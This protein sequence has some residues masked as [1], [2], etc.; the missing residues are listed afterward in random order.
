MDSAFT[1]DLF[2]VSF[3]TTVVLAC[4]IMIPLVGRTPR[5]VAFAMIN[6]GFLGYMLSVDFVVLLSGILLTSLFLRQVERGKN[7]STWLWLGGFM[8]LAIFLVHKRP[9]FGAE[10]GLRRWNPLLSIIGYSYFAL[11]LVEVTRGVAEQRHRSPNLFELINYLLPFHMISAGPI[12]SYDDFVSQPDTPPPLGVPATLRAVERIVS[13]MFKKFVLANA[14]EAV[15]LS[16]FRAGGPYFFL[17]TQINYVWLFLD[18]SAYSDIAVGIGTLMG[19]ATPEN[20]NRPYIARNCIDYWER[21]HISL[22]QFI[23][24]NL[25][26]PLQLSLVRRTDGRYPLVIASFAFAVSFL[27]C[28]L[29]H[30]IGLNWLAWGAYHALGLIICNLYRE[31]LLKTLGRKGLNRYLAN[32]WIRVLAIAVTFEF[33]AFSLVIVTYP[34]SLFDLVGPGSPSISSLVP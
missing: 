12:Q 16:T 6:L 26:I 14:L 29:W 22:S 28:G 17:E 11:R 24:R 18:F 10:L 7:T 34:W 30:N 15:F 2:S 20:F 23:R 27:L 8:A 31:Y 32:P 1:V 4:G 5:Q 9:E 13:G 3:W 19:V 21:W 25:F 33:V